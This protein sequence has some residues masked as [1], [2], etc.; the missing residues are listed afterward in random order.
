MHTLRH[1]STNICRRVRNLAS[2]LVYAEYVT[3]TL[4]YV[5]IRCHAANRSQNVVIA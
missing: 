4:L 5:G 2:T 3:D 1:V